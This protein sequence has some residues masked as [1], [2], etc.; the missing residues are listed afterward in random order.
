MIKYPYSKLN[1]IKFDITEVNS[2]LNNGYL[3]KGK[4]IQQIK[5]QLKNL[6]VI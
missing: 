2:F 6:I 1:I 3:T 5:F 4:K